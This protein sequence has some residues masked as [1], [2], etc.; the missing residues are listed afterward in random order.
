GLELPCKHPG[1]AFQEAAW[2][3]IV[4][5][6]LSKRYGRRWAIRD[7]SFTVAPGETACLLGPNGAGKSTILRIVAGCER[8]AQG[9]VEIAGCDLARRPGDARARIGYVPESGPAYDDL[10]VREFV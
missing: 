5:K 1:I 7:V 4:V 2:A 10:T 8:F 3:L 9:S 6:G